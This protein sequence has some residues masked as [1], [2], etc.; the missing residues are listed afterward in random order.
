MSARPT[1][2]F[3]RLPDGRRFQVT[4]QTARTIAALVE[5]GDRGVTALECGAWAF[6]LAAYCHDLRHGFGLDIETKRET[7]PGGWHG[8]HILCTPVR[9]LDI[10]PPALAVAA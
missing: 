9:I 6:R 5:A 7:H 8:R 1:V 2:T 10:E 4:G 3:E